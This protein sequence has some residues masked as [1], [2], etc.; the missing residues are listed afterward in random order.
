[1]GFCSIVWSVEYVLETWSM[2]EWRWDLL[3]HSR[4]TVV[5]RVSR[6]VRY[7]LA[8]LH[9]ES[10]LLCEGVAGGGRARL[11]VKSQHAVGGIDNRKVLR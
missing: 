6:F 8:F 4:V 10:A 2:L 3:H 7:I 5:H 9:R 11:F 1:M